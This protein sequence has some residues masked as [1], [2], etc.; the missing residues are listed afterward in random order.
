[1]WKTGHSYIKSKLHEIKAE[2][3]GERSGHIFVSGEDWYGFDDAI[4]VAAKLVEYLS[5]QTKT[6]SEIIDTFPHYVVSPEIKAHCADTVK[7]GIVDEIVEKFKAAYPGKV[8]DIN[9]ARVQFEHG[10]GLVRASSN[11]PELVLIFEADTMEHL[12]EIRAIFK[13][14]TRQYAEID[15]N[16]ANDVNEL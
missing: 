16:W 3:A 2:L 12:M 4:F 1:M 13:S 11:M 10:W 6:V 7:Y 9:G 8:C 5:H 14:Y 15:D